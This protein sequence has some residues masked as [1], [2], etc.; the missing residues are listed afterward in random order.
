M[1]TRR[2]FVK[3]GT[4][5]LLATMPGLASA[6]PSALV[7]LPES[8]RP[9]SRRGR[10]DED[11]LALAAVAIEAARRAGATYADARVTRSLVRTL[12]LQQRA[13]ATTWFDSETVGIGVRVLIDG[14]WGFASHPRLT[15]DNAA[16]LA[17]AAA[18]SARAGARGKPRQVALAPIAQPAVG[19]WRQPVRID[20]IAMDPGVALDWVAALH[21]FAFREN[22][23]LAEMKSKLVLER[24]ERYLVST[25]GARCAQ[26]LFRTGAQVALVL[27]PHWRTQ[28]M[29]SGELD[30]GAL[31]RAGWEHLR[32]AP[33]RERLRAMFE[34]LERARFTQPV[35]IGRY[36][37]V[38]DAPA[39]A[40]IIDGGIGAACDLARAMGYD[41]NNDGTSFL[42]DP[43]AM[44]D[45]YQVGSALV[46]LTG[47]RRQPLG[48]ATVRWDDEGVEPVDVPVVREGVLRNF[49]T[50]RESGSWLSRRPPVSSGCAGAQHA[51]YVTGPQ[52]VNFAL[53]PS[54]TDTTLDE[55]VRGVTRGYLVR[56]GRSEHD[57]QCA[58]G[59]G[60]GTR[61]FEI[62][63]GRLGNAVTGFGYVYR[64]PELWKN[65][66]ALGG[67]S[68]VRT[69]SFEYGKNWQQLHPRSVVTP[70]IRVN[71][72][73]VVD[74][75]RKVQ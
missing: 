66:A 55:L 18:G 20:P 3:A 8:A 16:R 64:T 45:T 5:A 43:D 31:A 70:A 42:D 27:G 65:T 4:A 28:Q 10:R 59:W 50:T 21:D 15:P 39:V 23:A 72:L 38:L 69:A 40:G 29:A 48:A 19:E 30:I 41:A 34:D 17:A 46:N 36:D 75:R 74:M 51:L 2:L 22:R 24:E 58:S 63:N 25:D 37:V 11:P 53:A 56:G 62:R 35:D 6:H 73:S 33:A 12:E 60:Q 13:L 67:A 47:S 26:T 61:V 7:S 71:N 9:A 32:D 52:P 49:L 57:H 68:T 44:L 14:Y 54:P 1:T